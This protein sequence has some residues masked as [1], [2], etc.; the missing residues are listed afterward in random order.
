MSIEEKTTPDVVDAEKNSMTNHAKKS[1][2]EKLM[3]DDNAFVQTEKS[4]LR[5]N[6]VFHPIVFIYAAVVYLLVNFKSTATLLA[7]WFYFVI[8]LP[9]LI[10]CFVCACNED[11]KAFK[12]ELVPPLNLTYT[13]KTVDACAATKYRRLIVFCLVLLWTNLMNF[14]FYMYFKLGN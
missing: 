12:G 8:S 2:L 1:K 3:R 14:L 4:Q 11:K 9:I 10:V 5:F 13:I 7:L 6:D